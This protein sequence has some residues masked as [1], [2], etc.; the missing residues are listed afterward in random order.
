MVLVGNRD[1]KAKKRLIDDN[2]GEMRLPQYGKIV[3]ISGG[4]LACKVKGGSAAWLRSK[5]EIRPRFGLE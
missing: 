2:F 3:Q 5:G 1:M 4:S